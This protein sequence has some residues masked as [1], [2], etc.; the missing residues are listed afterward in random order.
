LIVLKIFS[1]VEGEKSP[2]LNCF[3]H[4]NLCHFTSS[5]KSLLYIMGKSSMTNEQKEWLESHIPA[6]AEAQKKSTVSRFHSHIAEGWFEKYP[7]CNVLFPTAAGEPPA[8]LTPLQED[9]LCEA[10]KGRKCVS[11]I[12]LLV[13][14]FS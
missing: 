11:E 10:I 1:A 14:E 7:E 8:V 13:L 2:T 9:E 6:F 3:S 5:S 12:W 4:Y